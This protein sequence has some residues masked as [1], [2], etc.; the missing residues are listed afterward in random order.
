MRSYDDCAR[1]HVRGSTKG[2]KPSPVPT[3]GLCPDTP[4][5]ASALAVRAVVRFTAHRSLQLCTGTGR[6]LFTG[7]RRGSR[8]LRTGRRLPEAGGSAPSPSPSPFG[9]HRG[10]R[11]GAVSLWRRGRQWASSDQGRTDQIPAGPGPR[12]ADRPSALCTGPRRRSFEADVASV[13]WLIV[14]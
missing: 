14:K 6:C 1:H 10:T 2:C 13:I 4:G 11:D 9:R 12:T 8:G 5:P 3:L 7:Y